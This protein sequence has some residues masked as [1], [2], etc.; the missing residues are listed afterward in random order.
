MTD[1]QTITP[2]V[3]DEIRVYCKIEQQV[4]NADEQAAQLRDMLRTAEARVIEAMIDT[5]TEAITFDGRSWKVG[6]IVKVSP[7]NGRSEQVDE[8]ISF[9]APELVKPTIH[10]KRR[11]SYLNDTLISDDGEVMIPDALDGMLK[12]YRGPILTKRKV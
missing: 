9:R 11:E 4:A 10:W 7:E 3:Q 1:T 2:S 6:E 8:W 5:E 12:V